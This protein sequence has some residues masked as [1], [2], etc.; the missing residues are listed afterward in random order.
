VAVPGNFAF[1][2]AIVVN[3]TSAVSI[4]GSMDIISSAATGLNL[5]TTSPFQ[6]GH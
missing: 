6:S 1:T 2:C 4:T 3:S 5:L